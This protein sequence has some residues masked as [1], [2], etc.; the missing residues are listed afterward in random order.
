M[1]SALTIA[2]KDLRQRLRD[3]SAIVIAILVPLG[4]AFILGA[5]LGEEDDDSAVQHPYGLVDLDRGETAAAFRQVVSGVGFERVVALGSE[6]DARRQVDRG[7]VVAAF[8]IPPGFT[9]DVQ[10]NRAA[11]IQV[12]GS[13]ESP[14][15]AQIATAVARSFA[16]E[17]NGVRLSIATVVSSQGPSDPID[18][19]P[20]ADRA[21]RVESP[22]AID[23]DAAGSRSFSS[24][25][26]FAAGMAV[27]FVFFTVEFG[28]RSLLEERQQGT[29][30]R[31]LAAPMRPGAI[32]AGK[33]L[34]SFAVGL[35][36]M[37]VLVVATTL[38]LDAEWGDPVGVGIL[39]VSA[40][41]AAVGITALVTTLARTP[42]Q[43]AGYASI[44]SIFLGLLGGT[45][46]PIS[47]GPG[48][49]ATLSLLAPHAWLMR[50]FGDLS[51]GSAGA[52]DVLR[53]AAVVLAFGVGTG[54]L[55]L[56]RARRLVA[57]P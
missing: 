14:I 18:A 28:V 34:A 11:E 32:I 54:A 57:G 19:G 1:R 21:R 2:T 12:I 5:A 10:A 8:V 25:T 33:A 44:A 38:L 43:A 52:A 36:S 31:L 37:V 17:L 24:T 42:E 3:R 45:F 49:L 46:F 48:I 16:T 30:A 13:T 7:E 4:L 53:P 9:A 40:V 50:G 56:L 51:G 55:A 29:L 26:F 22:V 20:L 23:E 15:G 35:V 27:F 41:C 6:E 47:Q 39:I